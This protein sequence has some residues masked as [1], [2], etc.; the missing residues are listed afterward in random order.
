MFS[1]WKV[2]LYRENIVTDTGYS[3]GEN[4]TFFKAKAI[5]SFIPPD[6]T[7]KGGPDDCIYVKDSDDYLCPQRKIIP[8]KKVFLDYRTKTKKK[9]YRSLSKQCK[10]CAGAS[11]FLG[12]T[13]KENKFSVTYYREAYERN[14]ARVHSKKGRTMKAKRQST[15]EPVLEP[16]PSVWYF[17]KSIRL[18]LD[19]LTR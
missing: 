11:I 14:I 7:Y 9:E 3:S 13:A 6:G 4:D 19:R 15:V 1:L 2:G 8:F 10:G 5:T 12:K 18:E 17:R 16:L